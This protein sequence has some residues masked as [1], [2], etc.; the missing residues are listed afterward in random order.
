[1]VSLAAMVRAHQLWRVA[2]GRLRPLR[3]R[4]N[5][6]QVVLGGT[7]QQCCSP[8]DCSRLLSKVTC[9]CH[10]CRSWLSLCYVFSPCS[11]ERS[12]YREAS[13]PLR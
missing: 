13:A 5:H 10:W 3:S 11:E 1:M 8:L 7:S 4:G 9:L 6:G 2:D 12:T